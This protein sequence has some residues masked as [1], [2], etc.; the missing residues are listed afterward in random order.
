ML[1]VVQHSVASFV[2]MSMQSIS[3][4]MSASPCAEDRRDGVGL[5]PLL[6]LTSLFFKGGNKFVLAAPPAS[7]NEI[8][9]ARF[10]AL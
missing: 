8:T 7:P 3:S 9:P 10:P 6:R 2:A 4:V 5:D 1:V